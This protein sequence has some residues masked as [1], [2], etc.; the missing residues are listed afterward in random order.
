MT[1]LLKNIS[2]AVVDLV[3]KGHSIDLTTGLFGRT[4]SPEDMEKARQGARFPPYSDD[5]VVRYV[6][7]Y[8]VQGSGFVVEE[9]RSRLV[10]SKDRRGWAAEEYIGSRYNTEGKLKERIREKFSDDGLIS[11]STMV[12]TT[13]DP[14]GRIIGK[15]ERIL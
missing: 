9:E 15:R 8:K 4:L 2:D 12:V 1:S 10:V 3:K 13:F 5:N 7:R 14:P 11:S 6:T